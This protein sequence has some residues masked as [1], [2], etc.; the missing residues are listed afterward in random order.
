MNKPKFAAL[1]LTMVLSAVL[2]ALLLSTA[3]AAAS[4]PAQAPTAV[5]AQAALSSPVIHYQ[6]RLLDPSTGNP[7]PNG[8]YTMTFRLYDMAIGG[9]AL[10][11]EVKSVFVGNGLFSTYLGQTTP[12]PLTSFDGRNLW[13]GIKVGADS[14]VTPR[15][16]LSPAPYAIGLM[17]GAVISGN[18]SSAAGI[19][20]V[21]NSGQGAAVIGLSSKNTGATYG[22]LANAFSPDGYAVYG[23]TENGASA[24]AA[25][26]QNGGAAVNAYAGAGAG[27][28]SYGVYGE[29]FNGIGVRGKTDQGTWGLYS[30]QSLYVSG[31]CT[32]CTTAFVSQNGDTS[33]LEVGDVVAV[34]GIAP[35]LNGEQT[36]VL[37]VRRATA[38]SE[39]VLGVV[40]A[41]AVVTATEAPVLSSK[42]EQ[43]NTREI[44]NITPGRVAP[45]DYLFV[46][47]QGLVQ[48][49]VNA[50]SGAIQVGDALVSSATAGAVQKQSP[51]SPSAPILGRALEPITS[52]TGLIW[53]LILGR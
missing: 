10:W 37:K 53:V 43:M 24:L 46:V 31:T 7:K 12:L 1:V 36:P 6:G 4:P 8:T 3:N 15:V 35:P 11:T 41:R 34:S 29:S 51:D 28:Y 33:P 19:L 5:E 30:D 22:V 39:G 13:L 45:G 50:S 21:Y 48:V 52:G 44:A 42:S 2:A 18:L 47:V 20:R 16:A 25:N 17:P 23:Y 40:R 38:N 49:R 9:T 32:G 26:A 14:E 27:G